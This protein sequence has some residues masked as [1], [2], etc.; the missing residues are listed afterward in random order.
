MKEITDSEF[1]QLMLEVIEGKKSRVKLAEELQT[2]WRTLNKKIQLLSMTN[3]ELYKKFVEKHPYK[4]KEITAIPLKTM[5]VEF[6]KTG[7]RMQDLADKYGIGERT[8]RRKIDAL[9][10]SDDP[11]DRELHDICKQTA[12]N[13]AHGKKMHFELQRKIDELEIQEEEIKQ[14]DK[15]KRRQQ[16]LQIEKNYNE[17]CRIMPKEK[18]AEAMGYTYNRVYKLL[19]ELYCMEIQNN[20]IKGF[21][22]DIKV[23]PKE[24]NQVLDEKITKPTTETEKEK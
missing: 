23:N 1:E 16:L 18:A 21:K 12:Y 14:D 10:K 24:I 22:E 15:E 3:P 8:L 13:R 19:D 6:L 2:D 17:L 9:K 5:L 7:I 20:A 11:K 4:P